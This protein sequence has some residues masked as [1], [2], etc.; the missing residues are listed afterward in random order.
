MAKAEDLRAQSDEELHKHCAVLRQEIFQ[1]TNSLAMR[2]E[3]ISPNA[4]REKR[5]DVA[6]ILTILAERQMQ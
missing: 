2:K 4:I 1:M 6:R 3:E 5:K